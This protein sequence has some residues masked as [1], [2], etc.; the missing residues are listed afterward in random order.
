MS[1]KHVAIAFAVLLLLAVTWRVAQSDWGRSLGADAA[2]PAAPIQFDN[3]TVRQYDSPAS[4]AARNKGQPLPLGTL[5]KCQRGA[6]ISYTNSFCPPGSKELK[7]DKGTLTVVAPDPAAAAAAARA[8]APNQ[9][10]PAPTLRE[11][12]VERA[13]H[14]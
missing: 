7:M 11:L 2:R 14:Q 10:Q 5:R 1:L 13:V 12:A 8:A 9:G 4:L 3:G 6:E